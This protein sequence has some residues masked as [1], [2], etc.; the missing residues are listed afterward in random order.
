MANTQLSADIYT[1]GDASC[2]NM[3]FE[4]MV[5]KG[6]AYESKFEH[7][8]ST[9]NDNFEIFYKT[10]DNTIL[11]IDKTKF[12]NITL[13]IPV[14][15]HPESN[16]ICAPNQNSY[17]YTY[18]LKVR[19]DVS[20]Q[21]PETMF[22]KIRAKN[23]NA[24]PGPWKEA[25]ISKD[26]NRK[27]ITDCARQ[28]N[29][30]AKSYQDNWITD[31]QGTTEESDFLY[32]K[33]GTDTWEK[34]KREFLISATDTKKC[35]LKGNNNTY[36][37]QYDGAKEWTGKTVNIEGKDVK[38]YNIVFN[39]KGKTKGM[40]TLQW[41]QEANKCKAPQSNSVYLK[42]LIFTTYKANINFKNPYV[43]LD[44]DIKYFDNDK[45]QNETYT[46]PNY[47]TIDFIKQKETIKE[48][49]RLKINE[50]DINET[51]RIKI[52]LDEKSNNMK[53]E[54]KKNSDGK[55]FK[56]ITYEKKPTDQSSFSRLTDFHNNS[57]FKNN[58]N[59]KYKLSIEGCVY[60]K[61]GSNKEKEYY[62]DKT[63]N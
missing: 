23:E 44:F 52:E 18:I 3:K 1:R 16:K 36:C 63:Y 2:E 42:E 30:F 7:L 58:S 51:Y 62:N 28:D 45:I 39:G 46:S 26:I 21:N 31:D 5:K 35:I 8:D 48:I 53:L 10:V 11:K 40:D 13:D 59:D 15:K 55:V 38:K 4:I 6:D 29:D 49:V 54:I 24:K 33:K 20:Q 14:Q 32:R 17:S 47:Y 61:P 41:N 50:P 25:S 19:F 34:I 37:Q 60:W 12:K 27:I 43:N 9:K 56:D 57:V 22:Y